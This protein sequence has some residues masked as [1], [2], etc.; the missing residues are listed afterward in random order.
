MI[1]SR[2]IN[3]LHP[4]VKLLCNQLKTD[5]KKEGFEIGI[6]STLRDK[7]YQDKLYAQGRTTKG[8]IVTYVDGKHI[9]AHG[10][11]L[12]FDIYIARGSKDIYDEKLL[13]KAGKLGEKLGLVW[14]GRWTKLHDTPHFEWTKGLSY[15]QLREKFKSAKDALKLEPPAKISKNIK[16]KVQNMFKN[17]LG[18]K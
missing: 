17:A 11:G 7:E 9:G 16:I 14:G 12:A 13:A 1:D 4:Y 18:K 5:C 15:T 3:D 2:D 10:F 6:S 8:N